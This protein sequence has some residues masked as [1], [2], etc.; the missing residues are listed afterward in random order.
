MNTKRVNSAAGVILA[1]LTQN[2]T[3]AGI[4][5]ALESAQ[6]LMSPETAAELEKLRAE[7]AAL[8]AERHTT[9]EALDDVVRELRARKTPDPDRSAEKLSRILAPS[10]AGEHE[11]FVHHSYLVGHD[12]PETGGPR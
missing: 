11:V 12:L 2:R 6:M 3:A 8:R 5:L 4:A 1:A 7:V 9:N 10:P